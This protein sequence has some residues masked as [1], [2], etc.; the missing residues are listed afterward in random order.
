[1]VQPTISQE[2]LNL[3]IQQLKTNSSV[4]SAWLAQKEVEHYQDEPVFIVTIKSP[5]TKLSF[6]L[7]SEIK[8]IMQSLQV[9]FDLFVI[10]HGGDYKPLSKKVIKAG[11]KII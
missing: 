8:N 11:Q 6:S 4:R 7:E 2:H 5:P 1:L 3:L 10:V 9:P